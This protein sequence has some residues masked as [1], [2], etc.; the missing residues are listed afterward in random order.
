MGMLMAVYACLAAPRSTELCYRAARWY[1]GFCLVICLLWDTL[2]SEDWRKLHNEE[3]FNLSSPL[4]T[5]FTQMYDRNVFLIHYLKKGFALW[6][7]TK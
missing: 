7:L 2:G 6:S 3:L 4:N 1:V 5:L